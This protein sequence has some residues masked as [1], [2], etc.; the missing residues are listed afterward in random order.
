MT[1]K[2]FIILAALAI[3]AFIV[4]VG[5]YNSDYPDSHRST[6]TRPALRA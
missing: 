4:G 3:A 5:R 1:A 2:T 6:A